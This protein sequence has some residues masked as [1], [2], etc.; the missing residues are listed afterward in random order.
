ML[1]AVC[2][3]NEVFH[4]N[5]WMNEINKI[6]KINKLHNVTEPKYISE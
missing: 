5:N 6:N 2:W 4:L 1:K 3:S